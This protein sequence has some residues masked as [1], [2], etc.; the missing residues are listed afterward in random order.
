MRLLLAAVVFLAPAYAQIATTTSLV[1]T[2]TDGS[3]RI[4]VDAKITAVNAATLDTYQAT[5]NQ[6]GYYRIDFVRVGT[7][8]VTAGSAGF[9]KI[10]RKGS[11]VNLN[12]V[13]RNDFTLQPGSVTESVTVEAVAAVI[14]TDDATISETISTRQL[15]ELP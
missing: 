3:G 5:T 2:V 7:Y 8:N 4:I 1:G 13:V 14:K 15:S 12:Q 9:A 11:I 6:D 10:E